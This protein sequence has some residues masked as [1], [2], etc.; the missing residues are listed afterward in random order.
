MRGRTLIFALLAGV[1]VVAAVVSAA[2]AVVGSKKEQKAGQRAVAVQRPAAEHVLDTSRFVVVRSLDRQHAENYGR[3]AVAPLNGT[4]PGKVLLAGPSCERVSFD[5]REGICLAH[6]GP[7]SFPVLLL[8]SR[9]DVVHKLSLAGVPS[10]ARISP[11]GRWAGVTAFL[12]GHSYASTGKFSTAASIIDLRSGRVVADLEKNFTV[13]NAGKTV[14]AQ[15]R[16]YWGITFAADGDTFYATLA[17]GGRTWLIKGSIR[18]RTAHTVHEN[19]ECPSLSPDGTR[20]GYKKAVGHNPTV[21]RFTVLNLKT[22]KETPLAETRPIDDQVEWLDDAHLLYKVDETIWIA[23]ADGSG[24]PRLWMRAA[25]SP[26][27]VSEAQTG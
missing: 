26:A 4:T 5:A 3:M 10:R 27:T 18:R 23:N 24:K 13:T 12:T 22:G 2:V 9:L 21:W 8:D 11:D 19:V 14:T 6:A 20:I 7:T 16:N 25:D 1:C 15:D 17:T